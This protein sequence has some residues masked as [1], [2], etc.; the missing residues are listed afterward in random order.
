MHSVLILLMIL[1]ACQ[2][3][4]PKHAQMQQEEAA[5]C[6]HKMPSRYSKSKSMIQI[7]GQTF[8]MG[9]NSKASYPSERPAHL[10]KVNTFWIDKT[11]VTN[12][13]FDLFVKATRYVT[14]AE[15]KPEWK[16]LQKQLP[17]GTPKPDESVLVPASLVF[18]PPEGDVD[19]NQVT[20]WKWVP[21]ASWKQP[22][23]P[24]SSIADMMDH[25]VIHVA[26]EDAKAYCRWNKK[27]LP[28][29]A[30]WE[31]AAR[32]GLA[33]KVYAWGDEFTPQKKFMANTYQGEFPKSNLELDGFKFTSPVKSF[34]PNG[35]GLYDMI[36]NVWEW[37]SDLYDAEYY[38]YLERN[39][40]IENP[41]GS[42]R[43]FDP[44]E[45]LMTKHVIKGGS[46]LC[47]ENYCVN[48]RP[49]ARLGASFDSGA[50]HIGFRC[51]SDHF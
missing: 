23:G 27:R 45:P 29:E 4:K 26:L 37:T 5:S 39:K 11:E 12:R 7:S 3:G 43:S 8:N 35:Y 41:K 13:D 2:T 10:V 25:P 22:L 24:Q 50:S 28:T 20:W 36:G 9:T 18:T 49:S 46:F 44:Y 42:K 17:A 14:V 19:L 47:A 31:L 38:Q 15:Q 33:D 21:G 30:E 34:P 32:G 48:Y 40:V 6:C 1:P 51:A 16:Q